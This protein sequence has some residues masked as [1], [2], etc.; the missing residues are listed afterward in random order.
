[1]VY[2]DYIL[3]PIGIIKTEYYSSKDMP[4]QSCF[5]QSIGQ[6]ILHPEF[7]DGLVSLDLF[8]HIYLIY[9]NH[10]A[11]SPSLLVTPYMDKREHGI[12]ATRA[13]SRPNPLGVSVVELVEIING[14]IVFRGADMLDGTPLLDI[15]PYVPDFDCRATASKGWLEERLPQMDGSKAGDDR[16]EDS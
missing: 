7:A 11:S 5:S 1:M 8:S 16:F 3:R 9:W 12:F 13:P 15:K 10:K 6:A 2:S 14:T 4:I